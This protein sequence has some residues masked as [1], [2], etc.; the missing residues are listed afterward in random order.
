MNY[1]TEVRDGV[2]VVAPTG[3]LASDT[4]SGFQEKLDELLAAGSHYFVIDM[5]GVGFIDSS[6]LG[7]L[8]RLFKRV[9]IGEGDVR[10][11]EVPAPV[12]KILDLTRLTQV[13]DVFPTVPDAVASLQH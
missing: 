7:A 6:G 9:R 8:V 4:V 5:K 2:I 3:D 1:S 10:L 11:A 12:M 13:F